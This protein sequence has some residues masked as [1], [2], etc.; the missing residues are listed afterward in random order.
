MFG[1]NEN[2][3]LI[4]EHGNRRYYIRQGRDP[5]TGKPI[6][7]PCLDIKNYPCIIRDSNPFKTYKGAVRYINKYLKKDG[8][9]PV[10]V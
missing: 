3:T 10:T 5:F 2:D 8:V 1:Y 7:W 6:Y 4:K 9:E